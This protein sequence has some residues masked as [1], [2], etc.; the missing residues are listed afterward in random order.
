M[1]ASTQLRTLVIFRDPRDSIASYNKRGLYEKWGFQEKLDQ[2]FSVILET[3]ELNALYG[4]LSEF[5]VASQKPP[6]R[7]LALYYSVAILEMRRNVLP[8]STMHTTYNDLVYEPFRT[9]PK[10][11]EFFGLAWSEQVERALRERTSSI[12]DPNEFG[13]FRRKE[14]LTNFSQVFSLR[15]SNDIAATCRNFGIDLPDQKTIFPAP[16]Q[17]QANSERIELIRLEM[18][19]RNF[20]L[21]KAKEKAI[22][23]HIPKPVFVSAELTTNE[24]YGNFLQWLIDKG[25]PL[26][27]NG[28]PLFFNNRPQGALR[29]EGDHIYVQ[30]E[31]STHPVNFINWIGAASYC[32]WIGGRLPTIREWEMAICPDE[33][34]EYKRK[35]DIDPRTSNTGQVFSG[36]SNTKFFPPNRRGI[37]DA[38]GNVGIWIQNENLGNSIVQL[39]VGPQWNHT[40]NNKIF[41]SPRPYWLGTAGLGVRVVFDSLEVAITDE[42]YIARLQQ[43][44]NYLTTHHDMEP[45]EINKVFFQKFQELF[46]TPLSI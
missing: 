39:K 44:V 13:T 45:S 9:F 24:D 32:A 8:G 21:N 34:L 41:P 19:V 25:F 6:H 35:G 43:I 28:K 33:I 3:P 20:W 31:K 11:F 36:T 26:A 22:L 18:P 16:Q 46:S 10:V 30:S 42:Q 17:K 29:R 2:F 14:D 40:R 23:V 38:F 37:Y 1:Y 7:Q 15:E 5:N 12:R 4:G 27:I